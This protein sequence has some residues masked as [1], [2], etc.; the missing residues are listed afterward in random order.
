MIGRPATILSI[1]LVAAGLA[2]CGAQTTRVDDASLTTGSIA[3]T[4]KGIAL[5]KLGAAVNACNT[6]TVTIG[7]RDGVKFRDINTLRVV[8]LNSPTQPAVAEVELDPGE[9]HVTSYSCVTPTRGVVRVAS[10]MHL[11]G[12]FESLASFSIAAGEVVNTGFLVIEPVR[13]VLPKIAIAAWRISV[14]DWPIEELNRFKTQRPQLYAAMQARL[15]TVTKIPPVTAEQ[16]ATAC[17]PHKKLK[18]EGKIQ[19]LPALCRPGAPLPGVP[20]GDPHSP[21][22]S[23]PGAK[24]KK[25]AVD[26]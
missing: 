2:G 25:K 18:T 7:V 1:C 12:K 24:P 6:G 9:Y 13:M 8:G 14:R 23:Q 15:M 22:A 19:E 16:V 21:G 5:V 10:Q 11:S 17:E 26:A 20:A 4:K 3:R